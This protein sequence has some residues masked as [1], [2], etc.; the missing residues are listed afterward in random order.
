MGPSAWCNEC[1]LTVLSQYAAHALAS[2]RADEGNSVGVTEDDANLRGGQTLLGKLA[3]M[4]SDLLGGGLQPRG[5][6]PL[7]GED[8]LGDTLST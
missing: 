3:D 2:H 7:V 8:T 4:V 5:G 6:S 1:I